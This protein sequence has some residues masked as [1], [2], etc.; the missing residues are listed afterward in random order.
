VEHRQ[1][2][3]CGAGSGWSNIRFS[4]FG[5]DGNA[6]N[7]R[8]FISYSER[9]AELHPNCHSPLSSRSINYNGAQGV[10]R[11][12]F[13]LIRDVV[14]VSDSEL[15]KQVASLEPG[16]FTALRDIAAQDIPAPAGAAEE[17]AALVRESDMN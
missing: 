9:A 8:S 12:E 2:R 3:S 16:P 10:E 15:S 1:S 7:V 6:A 11:A 14:E 5:P 4:G 17:T 13:A